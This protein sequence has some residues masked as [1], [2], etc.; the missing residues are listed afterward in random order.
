MSDNRLII[1][2]LSRLI[3]VFNSFYNKR[4][5]FEFKKNLSLELKS[6]SF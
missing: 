5:N 4:D 6:K 2:L 3:I 1:N